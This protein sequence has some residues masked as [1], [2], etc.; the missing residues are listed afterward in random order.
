[1]NKLLDAFKADQ[2][3]AN[4]TRL[5]KYMIKHPFA[6]CMLMPDDQAFLAKHSVLVF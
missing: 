1:M 2:S 4:R 3:D 5:I 6:V